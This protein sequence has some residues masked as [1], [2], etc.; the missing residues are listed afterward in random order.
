MTALR[1][2]TAAMAKGFVRDRM[3]I[4]WSVVFPLMFLVLFGGIFSDRSSP[5][6][7]VVAVGPVAVLDRLPADARAELDQSISVTTSDDLDGSL[8]KLRSGG[9]AA[10][11]TQDGGAVDVHYSRADQ[12]RAAQVLGTF[13]GLVDATNLAASGLPPAVSLR[14]A[15]VED[16]SLR[17][18]QF[19]TPGLL[20]WAVAM[21]ATFGA[22]V[23]LVTWR[24]NGLLR[25]MRLAPVSTASVVLARVGVSLAV[26]FGQV[27]VFLAVAV[28]FFGLKLTGWWPM[29]FPL[30][31]VGTLAF[32]SIGLLAGSVAKTEEA[33]VGLA[34]VIVL[35][36]AFLSGSF[37][38]L[39]GAPGWL[40]GVSRVLPLRYLNE[41]MLDTMVRGRGPSSVVLP[42]L[43]LLAFTAVLTAVSARLF[44]WEP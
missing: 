42:V 41:A 7:D 32:L 39:A 28:A 15:Q 35:P 9:V 40:Q 6:L 37:F 12:V 20:G 3:T 38:S 44:R 25:R 34:N 23:N 17:T 26:A 22:A 13:R 19:V 29:V 24:T 27:V 14:T 5:R 2:L 21:S 16:T 1:S 43:V 30:T 33:A 36:M 11:V 10:V 31:L 18:I 4:F 8:A